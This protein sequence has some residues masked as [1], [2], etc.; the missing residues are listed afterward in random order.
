MVDKKYTQGIRLFAHLCILYSLFLFLLAFIGLGFSKWSVRC[1][2]DFEIF[3]L[4]ESVLIIIPAIG[5]LFYLSWARKSLLV[6]LGV[7][8]CF[9]LCDLA[10]YAMEIRKLFDDPFFATLIILVVLSLHFLGVFYLTRPKVKA[11]FIRLSIPRHTVS[12]EED[13]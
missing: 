9:V 12:T 2:E 8:S 4:A 13:S 10:R 7:A 5:V 3:S 11:E 1:L 6:V